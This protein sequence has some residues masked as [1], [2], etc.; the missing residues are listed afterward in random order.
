[1]VESFKEL[2]EPEV[3]PHTTS[4]LLGIV[5]TASAQI[6]LKRGAVAGASLLGSLLNPFTLFGY[7]VF[8]LVTILAVYAM[9]AIELK[10]VTAW[11]GL[12]YLLVIVAARLLL[13]ERLTRARIFGSLL[14][15]S[16]IIVFHL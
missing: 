5:L 11:T 12:T 6:L 2:F 13:Q 15:V 8:G 16:G 10:I 9:Q 7:A 4:M 3:L 1:M 14:I